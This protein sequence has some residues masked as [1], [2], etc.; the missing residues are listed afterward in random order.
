VVRVGNSS[1]E[2]GHRR[3]AEVAEGRRANIL[4]LSSNPQLG[5]RMGRASA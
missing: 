4:W 1:R 5:L 2:R 3:A